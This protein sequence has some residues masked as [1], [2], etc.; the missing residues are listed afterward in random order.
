MVSLFLKS[1]QTDA[2]KNSRHYNELLLAVNK[3]SLKGSLLQSPGAEY[4]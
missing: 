3:V 1:G 4:Y 2:K